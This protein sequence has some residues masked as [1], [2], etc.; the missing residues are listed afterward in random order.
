MFHNSTTIWHN[1]IKENSFSKEKRM[2]FGVMDALKAAKS[3][4]IEN[5]QKGGNLLKRGLTSWPVRMC[6]SPITKVYKYTA[7]GANYAYDKITWSGYCAKEAAKGVIDTKDSVG[8][9]FGELGF[10]PIEGM[11]RLVVGNFRAVLKGIFVTPYKLAEGGYN[12]LKNL[13]TG[14]INYARTPI[15]SLKRTVV[16]TAKGIRNRVKGTLDDV[17]NLRIKKMAGDTRSAVWNTLRVP[18]VAISKPIKTIIQAPVDIADNIYKSI[19]ALGEGINKWQENIR[20]GVMR[21]ISAPSTATGI[22]EAKEAANKAVIN[23]IESASA[24]SAAPATKSETK[25]KKDK[26]QKG[27]ALQPAF[28]H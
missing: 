9:G 16:D 25:P 24:E 5:A 3:S 26:K 18:V 23:A 17:M 6:F 15:K 1:P 11:K 19:S 21:T 8:R 13:F 22:M 12:S 2:V 20:V 7:K 28:V 4:A 27:R 14:S 10:A